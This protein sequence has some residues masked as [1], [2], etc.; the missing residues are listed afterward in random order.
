MKAFFFDIDGTLADR[1]EVPSSAQIAL[2]CLREN[3]Y[4]VFICTGRPVYYVMENFGKYC[5]GCICFNGR[6]AEL[7]GR[8]LYDKPLTDEEVTELTDILD[9]HKAGYWFFNNEGHFE[10]GWLND[11]YQEM[12]LNSEKV[13]N[14]DIFFSSPEHFEVLKEILKDKCI[15]N[16]HGLA[17]HADATIIGSDKG[18]AL[19][20]V[21]EKLN[22]NVKDSY[23]FGDGANDVSML[24]SAGHGIAM[25]N[26]LD[27]TK[28]AA[29]YVTDN[30]KDDGIYKALVHYG[31][32]K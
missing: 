30:M 26:A 16:P 29:E 7:N 9:E 6:Y 12:Q 21:L 31:L 19:R 8:I 20:A 23:A 3:G 22:I 1:F 14:F 32:F 25:G 5:D 18:L 2:N 27:I 10:G 28:E 11:H 15:F 24:K 13:Y 17:P 4:L